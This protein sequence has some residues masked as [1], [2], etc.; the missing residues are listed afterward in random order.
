MGRVEQD[1]LVRVYVIHVS[2][3]ALISSYISLELL[4]S[5]GHESRMHVVRVKLTD[6]FS[7]IC[8]KRVLTNFRLVKCTSFVFSSPSTWDSTISPLL[9]R[10]LINLYILHDDDDF[11]LYTLLVSVSPLAP[12]RTSFLFWK[13][14]QNDQARASLLSLAHVEYILFLCVFLILISYCSQIIL[15]FCLSRFGITINADAPTVY[16]HSKYTKRNASSLRYFFVAGWV[17]YV[18]GGVFLIQIIESRNMLMSLAPF[19]FF[20]RKYVMSRLSRY[21]YIRNDDGMLEIRNDRKTF[22][23]DVF[24]VKF[25][26]LFC[27]QISIHVCIVDRCCCCARLKSLI[28]NRTRN[29]PNK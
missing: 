11:S 15:V 20:L 7:R 22:L 3:F 9:C 1:P 21:F 14:M 17:F 4:F 2:R 8:D 23:F 25:N 26:Q 19:L 12:F 28:E 6:I 16:I 24:R 18:H 29:A 27:P 5:S 10:M 13:Q